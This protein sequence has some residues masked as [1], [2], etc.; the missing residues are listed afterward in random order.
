KETEAALAEANRLKDEFLGTLSHELRTPLNAVLG[1]TRLL[2]GGTLP[3]HRVSHA[4]SVIERNA[5]LQARLVEDLLDLSSIITGRLRL[6]VEPCDLGA[7]VESAVE[8]VRPAAEARRVQLAAGIAP[9]ARWVTADA[10][11][12]RQVCWNLLANAVKFT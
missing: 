8:A 9:E 4:L 5:R 12:L 10:D 11:R 7:I 2:A 3:P 1:W 6:Q